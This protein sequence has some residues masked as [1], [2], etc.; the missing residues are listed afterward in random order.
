MSI[1]FFNEWAALLP[2][3]IAATQNRHGSGTGRCLVLWNVIG[4][5]KLENSACVCLLTLKA[6]Q[7]FYIINDWL[8]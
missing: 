2:Y 7:C 1:E 3:T 4:Q 6:D 8:H 5:F